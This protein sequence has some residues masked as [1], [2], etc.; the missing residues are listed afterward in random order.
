MTV[1]DIKSVLNFSAFIPEPDDPTATWRK[2]FPNRRSI[3]MSV[4]KQTLIA[5]PITKAGRP[6]PPVILRDVKDLKDTLANSAHELLELTDGGWCAISLQTRYI[7]S[8]E[9]NLSRR[10]GSEEI[11]KVNPRTVLGGRYERGK[12]YAVTHNPETNSSILLTCDEEQISKLEFTFREA[13]FKIGRVCC[14]PYALLRHALATVNTTKENTQPASAFIVVFCE[15]AI[16]ALVQH[17]DKWL[18]LRSRTDVYELEDISP[19]LDLLSPFQARIP[20][21]MPVVV[22]ADTIIPE[23]SEK[24]GAVFHGHA[25][26]D[27]SSPNLLAT[28]IL[29]N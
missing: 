13:G 10:E 24:L 1:A 2:R 27:I 7:I 25:I 9:T 29:Q 3:I 4:S 20:A 15:G 26:Q 12:R 23:L 16:C 5:H 28:L 14:G 6:Q 8:L 18:E 11:I 17:E 21:E 22:V 19:A